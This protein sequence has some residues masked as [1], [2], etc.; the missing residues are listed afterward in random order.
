M[1]GNRKLTVLVLEGDKRNE[2]VNNVKPINFQAYHIIEIFMSYLPKIELDGSSKLV[3]H[4]KSKPDNE[5]QYM[6]NDYF[7]VSWY[8]V[9]ESQISNLKNIRKDKL[10]EYYLE[11]IVEVLKDIA[12]RNGREK[13]LFHIID[14]TAR[15]VR[16]SN[17][18][19]LQRVRHLS[20]ATDDKRYTANVYRHVSNLGEMW[21]VEFMHKD[22]CISKHEL[23]KRYSFVSKMDVYKK[24]RWEKD[25]FI[26]MDKFDKVMAKIKPDLQSL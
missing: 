5:E 13:E 17:Y 4:F 26:L 20:K 15:K 3:I 23:M 1:S 22:K 21:Y 14:E 18:E 25:E 10:S 2:K 11:I 16:E 9:D 6:K 19:M 7:N 8:Y 12:C 24:A